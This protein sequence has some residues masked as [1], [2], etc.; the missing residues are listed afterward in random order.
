MLWLQGGA[1]D[2]EAA[3]RGTTV[4]LTDERLDMLPERLSAGLASLLQGRDRPA[5]SVVWTLRG[6]D[7]G[8]EDV[9]FGRTIIRWVSAVLL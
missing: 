6:G 3:A 1:L 5:V 7:G 2:R 8:V 4:Y 9:W